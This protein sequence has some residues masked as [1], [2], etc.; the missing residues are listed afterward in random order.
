[1]RPCLLQVLACPS[2]GGELELRGSGPGSRPDEEI[3]SGTLRCRGCAREYPI[4]DSVPRFVG[5]SEGEGTDRRVRRTRASFGFEWDRYPGSRAEDRGIF[6]DETQ[7]S[8]ED[9]AG[10]FVLDAG[11]GMGR[12]TRVALSLGADVVAF[13]LSDSLLR[14]AAEA[15]RNKHLHVVQ[16]DLLRPPLRHES[17]DIVYSQGVIH[18]TADTR[19]AFDRLAAVVKRQGLLTV[20]VYGTPGS[21]RSFSTNPLRAGRERLKR[22]LPLAWL[23]V[24]LRQILSD[25]LRL[26]TTRL[27][28]PLLYALCYPLTIVGAVPLLKYFTFS[29]HED[30]RVRLI[31]NFDW[32]S[33]PFQS[34]HTKEES[35]AWYEAAGCE[36]LRHLPHGVVP[37][38]GILGRK[39]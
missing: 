14:L 30:F 39:S 29:V 5:R 4:V 21:Y 23:A 24:W 2:C 34:K 1:M 20:W 19:G 11:C 3:E 7:T 12:Y 33:P 13:D 25:S 6:L 38:V 26:L 28:V 8:S 18:H 16:G 32:L 37:K 31:E 15:R 35:R 9:W 10:R 22:A 27:P 17:F 36:V